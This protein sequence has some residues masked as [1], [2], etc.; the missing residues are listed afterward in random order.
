MKNASY[1]LDVPYVQRTPLDR[2]IQVDVVIIGGGITGVSAAYHCAKN[3]LKTA[4]VEKHSIASG[5]AG[6]NLGM[7]VEGLEIDLLE[8]AEKFGAAAAKGLWGK[9]V[10]A[11]DLTAAL[12]REH[13]IE[14]DMDASG[15]LYLARD[16]EYMDW[17]RKESAARQDDGF[18]CRIMEKG[19][20]ADAG[21][22][23]AGSIFAGGLVAPKDCMLDPVKFVRGLA[24]AAENF[25]LLIYENT[26]AL[27]YD[28]HSVKTSN[29]T[30]SAKKVVLAI[31]SDTAEIEAGK[32]VVTRIQAVATEPLSAEQFE[33][34]DWNDIGGFWT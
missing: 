27:R 22:E 28:A 4:L 32:T 14:C 26:D 19:K 15:S 3:G 29:G 11:R 34:M 10:E 24:H 13:L 21:E 17:L 18:S 2:D 7:V 30:V 8:A 16:S 23:F 6:K 9:T 25:G 20:S 12:V 33:K 5:S 31:E 1:W